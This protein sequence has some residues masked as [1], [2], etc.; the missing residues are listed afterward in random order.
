MLRALL[1]TALLAAPLAAAADAPAAPAPA[2]Q[3]AP[4]PAA[5]PT[6]AAAPA[7]QTLPQQDPS[8]YGANEPLPITDNAGWL[9]FKTLIVLALVVALIYLTLNYGARK[10]LKLGPASTS[11]VKVVD[12]VPLDPKKQLYVLQVGADFLLVGAS[13]HGLAFLS[14]LDG[15]SVQKAIAERIA[16]QA[17]APSFLDRLNALG[18]PEPRKPQ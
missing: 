3:A 13:E 12:R 4:A 9:L 6:P 2:A 7:A 14:K 8:L 16:A 5:A 15:E 1:V 11:L 18:K 10:L 17:A